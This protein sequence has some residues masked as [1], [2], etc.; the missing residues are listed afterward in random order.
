[1][2]LGTHDTLDARLLTKSLLI[3]YLI[4]LHNLMDCPVV[5]LLVSIRRT[6]ANTSFLFS[7]RSL[8]LEADDE[9]DRR[10]ESSVGNK[11]SIKLSSKSLSVST[12][13]LVWSLE[14]DM[15]GKG[16][17][18]RQLSTTDGTMAFS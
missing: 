17:T 15:L 5:V 3:L 6:S 16:A 12:N 7:T 11:T 13:R 8:Q 1:M 18:S 9:E 14:I 10:E 4:V 2:C